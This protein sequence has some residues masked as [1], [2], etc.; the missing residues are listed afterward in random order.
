MS[1]VK[2]L[3]SAQHAGLH[4]ALDTSGSWAR[5]ADDAAD[6]GLLDIDA[7]PDATHCR[8]TGRQVL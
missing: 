6:L 2:V 5:R 1:T 4:T 8:P 3:K 7:G